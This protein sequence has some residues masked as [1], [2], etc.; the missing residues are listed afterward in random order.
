MNNF[1]NKIALI[2]GGNSG[3]GYAAA[4]ELKEKGATV[5]ITG[6][7]KDA[8]EK[9]ASELGVTGIVADQSDIHATEQLV[10]T[11]TESYG[12][13]DILFIN[14]GIAAISPIEHASEQHFDDIMNIN[15]KGAYFT[16]SKFIPVLRDGGSVVF[17][18]SIV[19]STTSPAS[20]IY[21]A[22]KAALNSVM[23]SAALEL[24]PR[25]IRVN[26]VSPGPITT[27]IM[28]K[29]GLD[30]ATLGIIKDS[31]ITKSP[32]KRMGTSAEVASVVTYLCADAAGFITGSEFIIDGGMLL[33]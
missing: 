9:A 15:F 4:R 6:R 8:I 30:D 17:L 11:V 24:A 32:L 3:I 26:A 5:I 2:T 29:A 14:A 28:H 21:S 25:K 27:E 18:S 31:L 7:R 1:Q 13:V 22:S 19:A 12:Q 16:L 10:A 20:S 23:K 33:V